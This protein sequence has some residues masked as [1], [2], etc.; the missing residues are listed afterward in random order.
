MFVL[1]IIILLI[2]KRWW[3]ILIGWEGLGLT[4]FWLVAFYR[5]WVAH[6][7]RILTFI[8]NRVG[9][10][11]LIFRGIYWASF[12]INFVSIRALVIL[13]LAL[14]TKSSQYPFISWLPAA[15]NAPTPIR[16]LVHSRTLV[17]AGLFLALKFKWI[18]L[19]FFGRIFSFFVG[20]F[21][22]LLGRW[23]ALKEGD[24]KK[25]VA[26]S[27]I[28][29]LGLLLWFF[30][31]GSLI[32]VLFHL[33]SHAFFKRRL[34]VGVGTIIFYGF[35]D[36]RKSVLSSVQLNSCSQISWLYLTLLNLSSIPFLV[37]FYSKEAAGFCLL[38]NFSWGAVLMFWLALRITLSYSF[39]LFFRFSTKGGFILKD[40]KRLIIL[41][42]SS[43]LMV[44]PLLTL[45]FVWRFNLLLPSLGLVNWG[46]V[47]M[48]L[49]LGAFFY[50]NFFIFYFI[51]SFLKLVILWVK[52]L[53]FQ[54]DSVIH[55]VLIYV[56][57]LVSI[58]WKIWT[59]F[60]SFLVLSFL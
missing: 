25:I 26:F 60:L 58:N 13:M 20:L 38:S 33:V 28:R 44:L 54:I 17:T 37:G 47:L 51:T 41:V 43:T 39:R 31:R 22:L 6:N 12:Y 1:R 42:L 30:S 24:L 16:A 32:L 4:S 34:F 15:I 7:G 55:L 29:Q 10:I 8:T 36:Q 11:C 56:F 21:T 14:I 18:S 50:Q 2:R 27:T 49:I 48:I 46:A 57:T 35:R 59:L 23:A 52:G 53:I 3:L 45:G 9:D 19:G 5:R 40:Q